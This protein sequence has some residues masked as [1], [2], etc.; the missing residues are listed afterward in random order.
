M[1]K[2]DKVI[3]LMSVAAC[4]SP[5][6]RSCLLARC[7][8]SAC[9]C[10]C[11]WRDS[12]GWSSAAAR[13]GWPGSCTGGGGAKRSRSEPSGGRWW[14]AGNDR[15]TSNVTA[16]ALCKVLLLKLLLLETLSPD[17]PWWSGTSGWCRLGWKATWTCRWRS[18]GKAPAPRWWTPPGSARTRRP[19]GGPRWRRGNAPASSA[20]P[21][22]PPAGRRPAA[23]AA[24]VSAGTAGARG[25]WWTCPLWLP[26]PG[27]DST[28]ALML[29]RWREHHHQHNK[30]AVCWAPMNPEPRQ[31]FHTKHEF[32]T[33]TQKSGPTV[34]KIIRFPHFALNICKV[35]LPTVFIRCW[36]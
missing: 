6:R 5:R 24:A 14:A 18:A 21:R 22:R 31:D 10:P 27:H 29:R 15:T 35:D 8:G 11:R 7:C 32:H 13:S 26:P 34:S 1:C 17:P 28:S 2:G 20:S 23:P 25:W 9:S 4:F 33:H 36:D 19:A 16:V 12:C 30:K 3:T